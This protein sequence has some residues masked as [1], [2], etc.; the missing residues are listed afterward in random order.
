M[1]IKIETQVLTDRS[2]VYD[3]VLLSDQGNEIRLPC[4]DQACARVLADMIYDAVNDFTVETAT[5]AL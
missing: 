4:I 5:L 3:V 2:R 1:R